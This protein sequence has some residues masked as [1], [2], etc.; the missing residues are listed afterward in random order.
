MKTPAG[1]NHKEVKYSKRANKYLCE[2]KEN[3]FN[4]EPLSFVDLQLFINQLK[5]LNK[6]YG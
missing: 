6:K 4:S 1:P 2:E 3:N 5:I